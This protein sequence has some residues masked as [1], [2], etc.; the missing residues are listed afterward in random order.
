M[1][2]IFASR[3]V[4]AGMTTTV[5][6]IDD[7]AVKRMCDLGAVPRPSVADAARDAHATLLSLPAP[8][9]VE[10]VVQ[11]VVASGNPKP[12][13]IDT[14]T[15]D[16]TTSVRLHELVISRGGEFLEAPVSGSVMRA[17]EGT[18]TIMAGG[19][20]ETLA[21]CEPVLSIL[22][23]NI[24]HMGGPGT[25]QAAKLCNNA[26]VTVTVCALAESL[27]AGVKSG[28]DA[29][30]LADVI[31]HSSGGSWLLE[32]WLPL[33][34]FA[35]DYSPRFALEL[36]LKDARLFTHT[37]E[38]IGVQTPVTAVA[39]QMLDNA[40]TRGLGD[41]DMTAVMQLYEGLSGV[42]LFPEPRHHVELP[43]PDRVEHQGGES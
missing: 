5:F 25:G 10:E 15:I 23:S 19:S 40:S 14:S 29:E 31:C 30:Q 7:E 12:I 43:T 27:L 17:R 41:R 4:A 20:S 11:G 34:S 39:L 18:L 26:L 38:D 8:G 33:T 1:G 21:R 2:S 24:V 13:V 16:P 3:L 6:D 28:L 9:I 42:T 36:L 22:G 35:G 32:H 37:A